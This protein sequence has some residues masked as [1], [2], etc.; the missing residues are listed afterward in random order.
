MEATLG[1]LASVRRMDPVDAESV[2]AQTARMTTEERL[3]L[4]ERRV[5][6]QRRGL[7]LSWALLG[8]LAALPAAADKE[9]PPVTR[10]DQ[11]VANGITVVS[12]EGKDVVRI[13]SLA[14]G[15]GAVAT[16]T[17]AGK[18]LV[19]LG[20]GNNGE[21]TVTT[22]N[23]AGKKLVKLGALDSDT[24]DVTTYGPAGKAL[25]TLSATD[26]RDG[27]VI[28][29]SHAGKE[30]VKLT[31]LEGDLGGVVTT[32]GPAGKALVDLAAGPGGGSVT[33]F[34]PAGKE[35]VA[36]GANYAGGFVTTYNPVGKEMVILGALDDAGGF[37]QISD[38][39]GTPLLGTVTL[40]TTGEGHF[41]AYNR[42]GKPRAMWP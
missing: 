36:L 27:L 5:V 8:L 34:N 7:F 23:P 20:S 16:F 24:G 29:R 4:L 11:I 15:H 38:K 32:Y 21:G 14:N 41:I 33:T 18:A 3:D 1:Y 39:S 37:L 10:F 40:S 31:S 22:F 25:V 26:N 6:L 42:A 30:L 12:P 17:P 13:A 35:L 2:S 28:T 9:P 19:S